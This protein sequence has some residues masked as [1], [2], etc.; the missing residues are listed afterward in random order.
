MSLKTFRNF[1]HVQRAK[2]PLCLLALLSFISISV[3]INCSTRSAVQTA[4]PQRTGPNK[5]SNSTLNS[6]GTSASSVVTG[7]APTGGSNNP[8]GGSIGGETKLDITREQFAQIAA[9]IKQNFLQDIFRKPLEGINQ[10]FEGIDVKIDNIF[11]SAKFTSLTI[12]PR[13]G[14]LEVVVGV[15]DVHVN[16]ESMY[17][18]KEVSVPILGSQYLDTECQDT[19]IYLAESAP[20]QPKADVIPTAANNKVTINVQNLN[21][22]MGSAPRVAGPASCSGLPLIN[23]L[24]AFAVNQVMSIVVTGSQGIIAAQVQAAMSG[25]ESQ[26]NNFVV[27]KPDGI[28]GFPSKIDITDE[29]MTIYFSH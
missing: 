20:M 10:N 18:G 24:V 8:L 22:D 3:L 19:T 16:L 28:A 9:Q 29:K 13:P 2:A 5:S 7:G 21:V 1:W 14:K 17:F 27:S 11:L 23:Q 15:S 26:I 12:T 6:S 4:V 25:I